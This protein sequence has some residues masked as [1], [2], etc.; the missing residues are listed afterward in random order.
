MAYTTIN[1]HTDYFNTKLYSGNG[2]NGNAQTG[3]G[4][5]PDF[6]WIKSRNYGSSNVLIDAVRGVNKHIISNTNAAE[7]TSTAYIAS[8]N[9]DG[10]T[11]NNDGDVNGSSRT[12]ASWNWKAGGGQGSSNTDGTINTTYTSANTTAGFSISK[13]SGTGSNGTFGHGLGVIPDIVFWKRTDNNDGAVNWIVGG[14]AIGSETKLVLNTNEAK[15]TNSAFPDTT[16]WTNQVVSVKT[17]EGQNDSNATYVAYAFASKTG[18]SKIGT[19]EGNN[20]AANGPFVYTGLRPSFIL[21]KNMDHTKDWNIWDDKRDI[22]NP[23]EKKLAP[24]TSGVESTDLALDFLSNGFKLRQ[25]GSN[26]NDSYTYFY[27]AFGQSLVG[28]NNV[29]CNAR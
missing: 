7:V 9:S 5:Q 19:Y 14:P 21:I 22:D 3:V 15:T 13:Y 1:K 29:P 17:Y 8:F 12:Y 25:N 6:T 27:M 28:S 23:L 16:S 10:F 26:F 24:S 20:S 18:Y 11:L 2:S 4:F